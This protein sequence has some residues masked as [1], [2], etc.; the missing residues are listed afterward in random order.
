VAA[1]GYFLFDNVIS[2]ETWFFVCVNLC[3][4]FLYSYAKLM[5]AQS[6]LQNEAK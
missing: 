1:L 3:G 5:T 2:K 6:K 4:G